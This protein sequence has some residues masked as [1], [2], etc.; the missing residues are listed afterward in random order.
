MS[1]PFFFPEQINSCLR[2][3]FQNLENVVLLET[4]RFRYRHV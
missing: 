2:T 3:H 1:H 4:L